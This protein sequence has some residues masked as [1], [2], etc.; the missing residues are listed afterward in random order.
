MAALVHRESASTLTEF[1]Q[2][3]ELVTIKDI[4]PI[5]S[6][7]GNLTLKSHLEATYPMDLAACCAGKEEWNLVR[8]QTEKAYSRFSDSWRSLHPC[9]VGARR[10]LLQG[11]QRIVEMEDA[12]VYCSTNVAEHSSSVSFTTL[13]SSSSL[14]ASSS[15]LIVSSPKSQ[16]LMQHWEKS[17]TNPHTKDPIWIWDEIVCLRKSALFDRRGVTNQDDMGSKGSTNASV[18]GYSSSVAGHLSR[19]HIATASAAVEQ[20]VLQVNENE[21]QIIVNIAFLSV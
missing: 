10:R 21:Y 8:L 17:R 11:L 13:H 2:F 16:L 19:L 4:Q 5:T 9:A 7:G 12:S 18:G 3:L 1:T 14:S 6:S 20:G 15:S